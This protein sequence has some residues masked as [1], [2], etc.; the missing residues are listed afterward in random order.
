GPNGAGKTTTLLAISGLISRAEGTVLLQGNDITQLSPTQKAQRGLQHVPEDRSLFPS[1]TVAET[2]K[3]VE[4][5]D[6]DREWIDDL[7]P[8]LVPLAKRPV[9]A[10]S[11]GEQQMLTLARAL[12]LGPSVLMVDEMSLGLA[13]KIVASLFPV[14]RRVAEERGCGVL[15]VEQHVHLALDAVDRAYVIG[16]GEIVAEG[17]ADEIKP[18][19]VDLINTYL[20]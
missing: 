6:V 12:S 5:P 3:L 7:F 17:S 19:I 18:K 8:A 2:L 1:L 20:G 10:L 4:T 14:L 15:I 13:P 11:G 9:A 16:D